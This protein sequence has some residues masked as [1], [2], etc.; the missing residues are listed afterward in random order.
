[1][2]LYAVKGRKG[3]GRRKEDEK[4]RGVK[5]KKRKGN[6]K[7]MDGKRRRKRREGKKSRSTMI[8][9]NSCVIH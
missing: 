6:R 4:C 9:K 5:G 3:N 7:G 8:D 2:G 1:M